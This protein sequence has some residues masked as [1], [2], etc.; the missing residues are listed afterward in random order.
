[1]VFG[2]KRKDK[3]QKALKEDWWMEYVP[4]TERTKIQELGYKFEKVFSV[5]VRF[6]RDGDSLTYNMESGE[7]TEI[8]LEA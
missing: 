3:P 2:I 4:L 1:M 5:E 7:I 8:P 6:R